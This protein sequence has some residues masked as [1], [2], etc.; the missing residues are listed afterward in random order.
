MEDMSLFSM[1]VYGVFGLFALVV[2]FSSWF[3]VE[4]QTTAVIERFGKD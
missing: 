3:T 1:I 2:F 4:Q